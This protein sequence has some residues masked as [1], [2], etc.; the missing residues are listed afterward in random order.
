MTDR[1]RLTDLARLDAAATPGE[2][3]WR[4]NSIETVEQATFVASLMGRMSQT[5][6]PADAALI[7]YLRNN[8]P[9]ILDWDR[10]TSALLQRVADLEDTVR[11]AAA[12]LERQGLGMIAQEVR[13]EAARAA[14]VSD[15][16][17]ETP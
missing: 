10:D 12:V 13:D 8:V 17:G 9:A 4:D 5:T 16:A 2:W 11:W 3:R 14:L 6:G 15:T 1:T 7:V